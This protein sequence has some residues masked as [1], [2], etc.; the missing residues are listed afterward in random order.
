MLLKLYT[1]F[2]NNF[3]NSIGYNQL[4]QS[5]LRKSFTI[6]ELLVS[7]F[8]PIS[9]TISS[10]KTYEEIETNLNVLV[11]ILCQKHHIGYE[12]QD[13]SQL[14]IDFVTY[15]LNQ[16]NDKLDTIERHL[17]DSKDLYFIAEK[18]NIFYPF[19]TIKA[20]TALSILIN[21]QASIV[22]NDI[23]VFKLINRKTILLLMK[24]V[25]NDTEIDDVAAATWKFINSILASGKVDLQNATEN[26]LS[27]IILYL[28]Q[29]SLSHKMPAL[30]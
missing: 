13:F 25:S 11:L 2:V 10:C 24:S 16:N 23:T 26:E 7:Q 22:W 14:E 5:Y 9:Q 6:F 21:S 27:E 30:R 1:K 20:Y 18:R 15:Y 3:Q 8:F 19:G 17:P 4:T 28:R 29:I 12:K